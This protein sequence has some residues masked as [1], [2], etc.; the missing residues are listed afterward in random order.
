M[1]LPVAVAI[2][3]LLT[4]APALSQG[5]NTQRV[6]AD[7]DGDGYTDTATLRQESRNVFVT[8]TRGGPNAAKPQVL[9][10]GVDPARQDAICGLPAALAIEQQQCSPMDETLAGCKAIPNS[11]ALRLAG[12]ECDAVHL[13][14]NHDAGE[15][16]WWRL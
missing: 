1:K 12:G 15:M 3:F 11:A 9:A 2:A 6:T 10:F 7:F 13:Y 14:W 16:D 5:R 8:V 4:C